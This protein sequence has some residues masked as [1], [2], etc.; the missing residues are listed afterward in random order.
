M[1]AMSEMSTLPVDELSYEEALAQLELILSTLERDDLPLETSLTLYER[2]VVLSDHCTNL[3][4]AAELR[5]RKWQ[6]D[7]QT[8]LFTEWQEG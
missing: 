3:L 2:G 5:V 1:S 8:V 6:G 4:N 7:G